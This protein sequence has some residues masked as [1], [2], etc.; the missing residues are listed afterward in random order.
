MNLL[1]LSPSGPGSAHVSLSHVLHAAGNTRFCSAAKV[2]PRDQRHHVLTALG[3]LYACGSNRHGQLGFA[4]DALKHTDSISHVTCMRPRVLTDIA[5]GMRHSG[6]GMRLTLL[7]FILLVSVAVDDKGILFRWGSNAHGQLGLPSSV[8]YAEPIP[9]EDYVSAGGVVRVAAGSQHSV[10]VTDSGMVIACGG[11]KFAQLGQDPASCAKTF[12]WV[13]VFTAEEKV[14]SLQCGFQHSLLLLDSGDVVGWGRGDY[15]QLAMP[16]HGVRYQIE[17]K[18]IM[19][20]VTCLSV[21]SE[22]A[23]CRAAGTWYVW[24][25]NEHGNLGR[26]DLKNVFEPAPLAFSDR[27]NRVICG[28]GHTLFICHD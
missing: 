11:N 7:W 10:A 21:G 28:G 20:N 16:M 23:V 26:D 24:G 12:E 25:W 19:R 17:P 22:H 8:R 4:R 6:I 18:V 13:A 9:C 14:V 15:G 2:S 5:A 27:I 3:G 1:N